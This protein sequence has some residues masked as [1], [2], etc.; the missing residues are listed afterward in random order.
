MKLTPILR[1]QHIGW[2]FTKHWQVQGKKKPIE[3]GAEAILTQK[4]IEVVKPDDILRE[5]RVKETYNVIG[6]GIKKQEL[7]YTHPD[8][9]DRLLLTYKDN[10]VLLEGLTQA[11]LITKTIEIENGLPNKSAT[12]IS[13]ELH[14]SVRNITLNSHVLDAEQKKL[15]KLKDPE[16]P[17]W[18]FP[19]VYGV[20]QERRNKQLVSKL[21][22]LIENNSDES[23]VNDRYLFNDLFFSF[24]FEKNG[25]LIQFQLKGDSLLTS[26]KP[27]NAVS[28]NSLD[29]I[30][31]PDIAPLKETITLNEE[32]VYK[33][34]DIYPISNSVSKHHPHTLFVHYDDEIVGNLFEEEVT[35]N[36][37][38]GRSLL[39]TFT[40]A[41][42][43]ARQEFGPF[44]YV[45]YVKDNVVATVTPGKIKRFNINDYNPTKTYSVL[46]QNE[47]YRAYI[48]STGETEEEAIRNG[49]AKRFRMPNK[50]KLLDELE[51]STVD[52]DNTDEKAAVPPKKKTNKTADAIGIENYINVIG[53]QSCSVRNE[54]RT[55]K[56]EA[57]ENNKLQLEI[58]ELKK[59]QKEFE[60]EIKDLRQLNRS[61]QLEV[62]DVMKELVLTKF[63]NQ[64]EEK[65]VAVG[66]RVNGNVYLGRDVW[67]PCQ[68]YDSAASKAIRKDYSLFIKEIAVAVFG[69]NL[70][71][72]SS[73]T[74][75]ASNR[76]KG[77]AK[78]P[79]DSTK[80][81]N[82]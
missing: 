59:K 25:N 65:E 76:V 33:L 14:K 30:D 24:P 46:Y 51:Y 64:Q 42:S 75:I 7:D 43:Y 67:L 36:Q 52:E 56:P 79:L 63:V 34:Q 61:L 29:G 78:P 41:A 12:E 47:Y 68:I 55:L 2:H 27:L 82:G 66:D 3:T 58:N 1:K 31:L 40:V 4:G 39:K 8:W 77:P 21:I 80:I 6:Y 72:Q 60:K 35:D 16:R 32:N 9:N 15:P 23:I 54:V 13:K 49:T 17:A 45:K 53:E 74:G 20:T 19:R 18:N 38:F 57:K 26:K 37:I 28:K 69:Q 50:Q 5:K 22:Q 10:N 81:I 44:V 71:S 73:V 11:K 62:I 48:I 70:L